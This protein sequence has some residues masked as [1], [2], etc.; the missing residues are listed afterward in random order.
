MPTEIYVKKIYTLC[1]WR[2]VLASETSTVC[3][4]KP[5]VGSAVHSKFAL[6]RWGEK[7]RNE[8]KLSPP[9]EMNTFQPYSNGYDELLFAIFSKFREVLPIC[10]IRRLFC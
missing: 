10:M 2:K 1:L 3:T 4:R 5:A 6:F 8:E 9:S 7:V